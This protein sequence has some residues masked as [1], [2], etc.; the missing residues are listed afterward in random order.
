MSPRVRK[1]ARNSWGES[2]V[3]ETD[4]SSVRQCHGNGVSFGS[5]SRMCP[6]YSKK[7]C[8][9]S[10]PSFI[11]F[12]PSNS[13]VGSVFTGDVTEGAPCGLFFHLIKQSEF[14]VYGCYKCADVQSAGAWENEVSACLSACSLNFKKCLLDMLH[15][16]MESLPAYM[17][18][19]KTGRCLC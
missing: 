12:W 14:Q 2:R 5:S 19:M 16:G 13:G 6:G 15:A 10:T 17:T 9:E 1:A 18:F 7:T 11:H 3:R 8:N 4:W